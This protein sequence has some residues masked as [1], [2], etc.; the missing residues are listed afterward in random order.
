MGAE[1]RRIRAGA[2]YRNTG[3]SIIYVDR[4]FNHPSYGRLDYDGDISVVRLYGSLVYTPGIQPGPIAA[5]RTVL[6]DNLPV[7]HAGWGAVS[8]SMIFKAT[9]PNTT[10]L[11]NSKQQ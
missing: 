10:S 11:W 5:Q 7:V 3:G 4:E 8:V 1:F 2:T 9:L 6:P